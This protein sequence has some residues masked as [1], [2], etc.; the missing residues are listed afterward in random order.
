MEWHQQL[1]FWHSFCHP[2][3]GNHCVYGSLRILHD[4]PDHDPDDLQHHLDC[5]FHSG[6]GRAEYDPYHGDD[7]VDSDFYRDYHGYE[8]HQHYDYY[9]VECHRC[10]Y[11]ADP[12]YTSDDFYHGLDSNPDGYF[13]GIDRY[14]D[15]RDDR[16]E[17]HRVVP[18]SASDRNPDPDD[19]GMDCHQDGYFHRA[20]CHPDGGFFHL[21]GNQQ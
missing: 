1:L 8:H 9:G 11:H 15:C 3:G 2:D 4:C 20:F 21:V 13:H 6:F 7:C 5:H 19:N 16:M 12:E 18:V 10:L 17:R 14:S